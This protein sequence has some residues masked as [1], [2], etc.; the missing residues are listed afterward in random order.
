MEVATGER[1]L[2]RMHILNGTH[3]DSGQT[4]HPTMLPPCPQKKASAGEPIFA[5]VVTGDEAEKELRCCG[6]APQKERHLW[7]TEGASERAAHPCCIYP[8][9]S[10]SPGGN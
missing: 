1:V 3:S 6:N 10:P 9:S 4:D 5:N 8:P 7:V 2:K